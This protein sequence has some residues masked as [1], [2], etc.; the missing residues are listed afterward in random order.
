MIAGLTFTTANDAPDRDPVRFELYGSNNSINGPFA[1][2][3]EGEIAD[4]KQALEWPRDSM[5][6]TPIHFINTK[7][8]DHY[9]LVF[10]AL[11]DSSRA[12]SMQIAEVEFLGVPE[13]G[14][15]PQVNAGDDRIVILPY[16]TIKLDGIVEYYGDDPQLLT[17]EW[18][19]LVCLIIMSL[20]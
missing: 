4:F 18:S 20:Q 19:G 8:Y 16:T 12:N 10:T 1:L 17:M 11:R 13:E 15:P 6:A 9:K 3:R 7:A 14:W 2:I 5:N